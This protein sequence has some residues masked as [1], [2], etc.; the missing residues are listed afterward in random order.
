MKSAEHYLKAL[1]ADTA[2][3]LPVTRTISGEAL[4]RII[5]AGLGF[6][7][8]DVDDADLRQF[9]VRDVLGSM[10][11]ALL[12]MNRK[13]ALLGLPPVELPETQYKFD[14]KILKVRAV[15]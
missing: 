1:N 12:H 13:R 14:G 6:D 3:S 10:H 15:Q 2:R 8:D 9:M 7:P 11:S 4:E 5:D